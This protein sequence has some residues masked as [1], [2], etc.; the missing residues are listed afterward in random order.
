VQPITTLTP[1]EKYGEIWFKRDDKFQPFEDVPVNGGK[2]RQCLALLM[3]NAHEIR[4]KSS[5]TVATTSSVHSPQGL[6]VTRVA[7]K[8]RFRTVLI[9]GGTTLRK[10]LVKHRMLRIAR[11]LGCD[12]RIVSKVGYSNVL[13]ARLQE[14]VLRER[15]FPVLYSMNAK[16]NRDAIIDTTAAQCANLPKD[17]DNLVIPVGSSVTMAG[18]LVGLNKFKIKPRRIIGIQVTGFDKRK[19]IDSLVQP[20][21]LMDYQFVLDTSFPY[22][23]EVQV[24]FNEHES[25][26]PIYEAKAFLW[27]LKNIDFRKQTTLFWVIGNSRPIRYSET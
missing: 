9:L 2:V 6:I 25:L 4:V 13:D 21:I 15:F 1:V 12:I 14:I 20:D 11:E 19:L 24:K 10:A 22:S 26:D 17:I 16:K 5:A 18:I 7:K 27:L 3:S 8:F 23:R